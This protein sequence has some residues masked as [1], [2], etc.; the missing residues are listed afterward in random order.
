ML[1]LVL[2]EPLHSVEEALGDWQQV[3][4]VQES[5]EWLV[6][7]FNDGSPSDLGAVRKLDLV[8]KWGVALD[9]PSAWDYGRE[10]QT[11]EEGNEN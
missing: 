7:V 6:E 9:R 5:C 10:C 8:I 11:K 1:E 3:E 4:E 2:G